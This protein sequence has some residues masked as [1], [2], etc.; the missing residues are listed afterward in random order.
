MDFVGDYVK[1]TA[2][3]EE[4]KCL[5]CANCLGYDCENYCGAEHGWAGYYRLIPREKFWENEDDE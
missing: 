3:D 2:D 1:V 5:K 4:P